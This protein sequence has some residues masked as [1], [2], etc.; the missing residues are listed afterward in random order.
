MPLFPEL[1]PLLMEAFE[2][3]EPGERYVLPS[4]QRLHYLQVTD[5]HF[6]AATDA[7]PSDALGRM[8]HTETPAERKEPHG[9]ALET[10]QVTGLGLEPRTCGLK[11]RCSAN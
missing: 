8:E 6:A 7:E 4:L 5:A 9:T 11:G 3:A 10:V 1:R 2:E